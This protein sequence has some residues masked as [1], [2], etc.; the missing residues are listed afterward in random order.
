MSESF[1]VEGV[2]ATGAVKPARAVNC[3]PM[4]P[5]GIAA[6]VNLPMAGAVFLHLVIL[7]LVLMVPR[8]GGWRERPVEVYPIRLY[9]AAE[10][11]APLPGQQPASAA[12]PVRRP[13][14]VPP[15]PADSAVAVSAPIA[16]AREAAPAVA[17]PNAGEMLPS[18]AT[19]VLSAGNGEP[20]ALT[21]TGASS[22]FEAGKIAIAAMPTPAGLGGGASAVPAALPVVLAQPLYRENREPEYPPLARRRQQ[23]GTVVLEALVG[24][25][26]RVAE[27]AVHLS[28]GHRLLD[29]AALKG[30]KNWR[31]VP[32]RRGAAPVALPVL[33]PVRFGLR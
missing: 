26:G 7:A 1:M 28:S 21:V 4:T 33:V 22:Q 8:S 24:A 23:E 25:D 14:V 30:V 32:G 15:A 2:I 9:S 31:F 11:A 5:P 13:T 20:A 17:G 27:L 16:P 18:P 29:E 10:V 12:L 6:G 3:H 19:P